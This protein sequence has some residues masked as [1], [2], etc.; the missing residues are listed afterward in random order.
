MLLFLLFFGLG[1]H[2]LYQVFSW[3]DTSGLYYS[4]TTQ[5][6]SL[7]PGTVDV[8]FFGP[9]VFYQSMNPAIFWE[10]NGISSFNAA[11]SGQERDTS[12]YYV[13]EFI[14]KQSPKVVVLSATYF[15]TD[16]YGVKGNLLRN[17]LSLRSSWNSMRLADKIYHGNESI[18][19]ELPESAFF[20]RWPIIHSRYREIQKNDFLPVKEYEDSLGFIYSYQS[21][22]ADAFDD[23]SF[24]TDDR[25]PISEENKAWL[26]EL[27]ALSQ[28]EGFELLFVSVPMSFHEDNRAKLLGCFQYLDQLGIPYLDMNLHLDEIDFSILDDMVDSNHVNTLGAAK[29]DRFLSQYLKDNYVLE[30]HRGQKGYDRYDACLKVYQHQQLANL[31]FPYADTMD[32]LEVLAMNN[33]YLSAFSISPDAAEYPEITE[34]LLNAGIARDALNAGG[35]WIL[36]DNSVVAVPQSKTYGCKANDSEYLYVMPSAPGSGGND[37]VYLGSTLYISPDLEGSCVFI[38]D[39]VLDKMVALKEL[40]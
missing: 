34:Y 16:T 38:Y 9:S 30:D 13:K 27:L 7:N 14:K 12:T 35:T 26:E 15:F 25:L 31:C 24:Q 29:L 32:M 1:L 37:S 8:A 39:Q 10:T 20:Y 3:K 36:S 28:Q 33:G 4:S 21:W 11:V 17:A 22:D 23:C 40:R 6:Y 19:E 2:L 5:M 18:Q